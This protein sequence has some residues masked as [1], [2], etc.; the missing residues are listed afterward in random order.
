M[1]SY[2]YLVPS[3][4]PVGVV[5]TRSS[6][7]LSMTI[8]WSPLTLSQA[9]GFVNYYVITYEPVGGGTRQLQ[10]TSINGTYV[11]V[12]GLNAILAYSVA[13]SGH[14]SVG[15]GPSTTMLSVPTS[16]EVTYLTLLTTS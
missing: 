14:T 13:V 5:V 16:G 11:V 15:L 12:S 2:M 1:T 6:D 9:R 10:T 4:A 8:R 3:V 7:G